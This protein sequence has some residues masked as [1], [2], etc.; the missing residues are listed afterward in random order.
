M[1]EPYAR[2]AGGAATLSG[3]AVLFGGYPGPITDTETWDGIAWNAVA[4]TQPK[5][6]TGHEM[7]TLGDRVVLY[8]GCVP[9]TSMVAGTTFSVTWTWDGTTWTQVMVTGPSA[10]AY[11]SMAPFGGP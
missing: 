3:V 2:Y 9:S 10:R 8:G 1:S 11:A 5:A 7:A 6:R 4:G